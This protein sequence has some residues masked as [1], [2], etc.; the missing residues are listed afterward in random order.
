MAD[1]QSG[2][3][4][5]ST[6]KPSVDVEMS[7]MPRAVSKPKIPTISL[8]IPQTNNKQSAEVIAARK[9]KA[10]KDMRVP[11]LAGPITQEEHE[12]EQLKK[13][14]ETFV[15]AALERQQAADDRI[16]AL[17]DDNLRLQA[18][19]EG[20]SKVVVELQ[21]RFRGS[22]A[23]LAIA[24]QTHTLKEEELLQ[25]KAINADLKQKLLAA[26]QDYKSGMEEFS[27]LQKNID[28]MKGECARLVA[29]LKSSE[30]K[31]QASYKERDELEQDLSNLHESQQHMEEYNQQILAH[32][33][34]VDQSMGMFEDLEAQNEFLKQEK[35]YYQSDYTRLERVNAELNEQLQRAHQDLQAQG[36]Q[37]TRMLS[38]VRHIANIHRSLNDELSGS[39]FDSPIT[40]HFDM[41]RESSGVDPN[42]QTNITPINTTTYVTA[43]TQTQPAQLGYSA[44]SSTSTTPIA[45]EV[46]QMSDGTTQTDAEIVKQMSD[47]ATQ[48]EATQMSDGATQTDTPEVTQMSEGA[49]QTDTAEL[50]F[51]TITTTLNLSPIKSTPIATSDNATQ[52]E[53]G[54][55]KQMDDSATQTETQDVPQMSDRATQ[56]DTPVVQPA[57][58]G[59]STIITTLAQAPSTPTPVQT[60]HSGTQTIPPPTPYRFHIHLPQVDIHLPRL[61]LLTSLLLTLLFGFFLHHYTEY[62]NLRDTRHDWVSGNEFTR[63]H[64]VNLRDKGVWKHYGRELELS[65]LKQVWMFGHYVVFA[66]SLFVNPDYYGLMVNL[67]EKGSYGGRFLA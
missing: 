27:G 20:Q 19:F 42:T 54:T 3:G 15:K 21:N 31:L 62:A 17:E 32:Q 5:G 13:D 34:E 1:Q 66:L 67:G 10:I 48:T 11:K 41:D 40:D 18:N 6:P 52:T 55:V 2:G 43:E 59:F 23:Q 22:Q 9:M 51:S 33:S 60:T 45:P 28:N 25:E 46:M 16:H 50:D 35:D 7:G 61:S 64:V 36:Q 29:K 44:I 14:H 12:N 57:Q 8:K 63:Q 49:T 53:A 30:L 39:A 24:V 47:G 4:E 38:P 58:L 37:E 56:T 26:S 65:P